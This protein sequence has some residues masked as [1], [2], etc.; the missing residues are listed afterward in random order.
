MRESCDGGG[1]Q[2]VEPVYDSAAYDIVHIPEIEIPGLEAVPSRP[3]RNSRPSCIPS[4]QSLRLL[5]HSAREP[6]S[7]CELH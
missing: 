4:N 1:L 3:S 5:P 7:T 6:P 2:V